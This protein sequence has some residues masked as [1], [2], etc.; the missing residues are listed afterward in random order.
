MSASLQDSTYVYSRIYMACTLSICPNTYQGPNDSPFA[1]VT[2]M[3]NERGRPQNL[4][5]TYEVLGH[6]LSEA[7]RRGTKVTEG[8][9]TTVVVRL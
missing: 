9:R 1:V 2:L 6:T 7:V 3:R 5:K 8:G 4:N